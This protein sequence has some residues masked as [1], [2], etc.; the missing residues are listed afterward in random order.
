MS[1]YHVY[2]SLFKISSAV[3][4]FTSNRVSLIYYLST[5]FPQ[6][7]DYLEIGTD[8]D[9]LF[10]PAS[11]IFQ[12]LVGVDPYRGGNVRTTS[13]L[14]FSSISNLTSSPPMFD[15]IFVD[16]LHE[17][18]QVIR[19]VL[20]ALSHLKPNGTILVN[21]CNPRGGEKFAS[22]TKAAVDSD[23]WSGD[24]WR[25]IVALRMREDLSL[26][27]VDVD[28]GIAVIR[29]RRRRR[30]HFVARDV[31]SSSSSSVSQGIESCL[32]R[33]SSTCQN[34]SSW[35]VVH[36]MTIDVSED[37]RPYSP[38]PLSAFWFDHLSS[39]PLSV[40]TY[41]DLATHRE[42]LLPLVSLADFRSW[43]MGSIQDNGVDIIDTPT[44]YV[45]L[46]D[47]TQTTNDTDIEETP[48]DY[49]DDVADAAATFDEWKAYLN[50]FQ[51]LSH[52]QFQHITTNTSKFCVIIETRIS[53]LL[54]LV[55]KNYMYLLQRKG[56]GLVVVHGLLNEDFITRQ[57]M[58][59]KTVVYLRLEVESLDQAAYSDFLM[60]SELWRTLKVD[61]S[62]EYALIFQIDSIL[63]R[64][65]IDL[66]VESQYDFVGAPW[67][68]EQRF[69]T[70]NMSVGNGGLS[71]R[72]VATMLDISSRTTRNITE[73]SI[74]PLSP[75][76]KDLTFVISNENQSNGPEPKYLTLRNEDVYFCYFIHKMN[77]KLPSV[78]I[79]SEFSMESIF[80]P[81][82]CGMHQP[83]CKRRHRAEIIKILSKRHV[84]H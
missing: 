9:T 1:Y 32:N 66:F 42:K 23:L 2:S 17:A 6:Y 19:D 83:Y 39:D 26:V 35:S 60:S 78:E 52:E 10:R 55:I 64:G 81:N 34:S 14:Y 72:R 43:L 68:D 80:H 69:N 27:V 56:W 79:A 82:P 51:D 20:N 5:V 8:V 37:H 53:P 50:Q 36:K 40:L 71:L 16:G 59:W 75:T 47:G 65:D 28:R 11:R 76:S 7:Q 3:E 58:G 74:A 63:L 38:E 62:C 4:D 54:P 22:Y 84:I 48:I 41:E 18:N 49:N 13:D 73:F 12:K 33:L 70:L 67:N 24:T 61:L 45:V 30:R 25:A 31:L 44:D 15:I 46:T 77:G 21:G 57:L 29:R